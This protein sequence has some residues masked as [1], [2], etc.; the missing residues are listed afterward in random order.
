MESRIR[1]EQ[2]LLRTRQVGPGQPA[3]GWQRTRDR[4]KLFQGLRSWLLLIGFVLVS[5]GF[6]TVE[7]S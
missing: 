2:G 5:V 3:E 7:G 1:V 4:W 6:T